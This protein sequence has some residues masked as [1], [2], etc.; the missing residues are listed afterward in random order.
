MIGI[1][2]DAGVLT[3][4]R[5][6]VALGSYS[7]ALLWPLGIRLPVLPGQ[8]LLADP[9]DHRRERC[10]RLHRDGRDLTRSP[11]PGWATVSGS[12]ARAE[13][14][15]FSNRLRAPRRRTLEHSVH[16]LFPAGGDLRR[17]KFWT[18]L[19]PMTP[20]GTPIVG[21]TKL[22]QPVH[23]HRSR[24]AGLDHGVRL[25]PR[26]GRPRIRSNPGH[27]GRRPRR[28]ALCTIQSGPSAPA[29][30][31]SVPAVD[32]RCEFRSDAHELRY[33]PLARGRDRRDGERADPDRRIAAG[34]V[35]GAVAPGWGL[36]LL[37]AISGYL[38]AESTR[39]STSLGGF[40]FARVKRVLPALALSVLGHRPR[41]RPPRN[42]ASAPQLL[43][44]Q[45]DPALPVQ[46]PADPAPRSCLA[47][48]MGSN[49][50][51]PRTRCCGPW[52][53]TCF[54]AQCWR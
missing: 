41:H 36:D 39:R 52:A 3:A 20:D 29:L 48:S 30:I 11:S 25:G 45:R 22:P 32:C 28:R 8:G 42:G 17:A 43:P 50:Q 1:E 21:P 49:G 51:G 10:A 4:D 16:D 7:S 2:T 44:G 5:Y 13:L 24:H 18:G 53:P 19:R 38:A 40:M 47:H 54:A 37:F 27:R 9:A 34:P 33:A 26:S 31:G 6:V 14:A 35:G 23:Q 15:G 46:Y 12:A